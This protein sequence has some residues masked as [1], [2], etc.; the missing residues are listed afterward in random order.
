[1]IGKPNRPGFHTVSPYLM[2]VE[3]EPVVE[4]IKQAFNGV[5]HYRTTGSRGGYHIELKVGNSM[6]MIGGGNNTVSDPIQVALFLYVEDVDA[7]YQSALGAGASAM[8]P[9]QDGMFDEERGAGIIDP[10]GN[11]WFIGRFGPGSKHA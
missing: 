11:S 10:F 9:P 2:V 7:V 4:F 8:M 6:I 3:V 1:M 5:E